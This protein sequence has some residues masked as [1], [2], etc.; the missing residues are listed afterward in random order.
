[1]GPEPGKGSAIS[2]LAGELNRRLGNA[3]KA[4][5]YFGKALEYEDR[6]EW[7]EE[8][9]GVVRGRMEK[10]PAALEKV[11]VVKADAAAVETRTFKDIVS[12]LEPEQKPEEGE[13]EQPEERE[14]P[15]SGSEEGAE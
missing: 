8:L 7:M 2:Y 9:V 11:Q 3:G 12:E 1:V 15:E 10:P 5:E 4:E 13:P 14:A 6:P